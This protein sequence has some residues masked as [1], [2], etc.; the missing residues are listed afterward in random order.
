MSKPNSVLQRVRKRGLYVIAKTVKVEK[1]PLA[2]FTA[3]YNVFNLL[4]RC[5]HRDHD[6]DHHLY[7]NSCQIAT[8]YIIV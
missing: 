3:H 1:V 5:C 6:Y 2:Y 7:C 4:L 8:M